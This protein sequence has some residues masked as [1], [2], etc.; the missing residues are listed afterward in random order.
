MPKTPFG[1]DVLKQQNAVEV[2]SNVT[3]T[4]YTDVVNYTGKGF[5]TFVYQKQD[6]QIGTVRITIDGG[7]SYSVAPGAGEQRSVFSGMLRFK[8]S[9]VIDAFVVSGGTARVQIVYSTD[10]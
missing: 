5:L 2:R 3:A 8:T 9:L 10:N 1:S 7:T 6:S 4:S